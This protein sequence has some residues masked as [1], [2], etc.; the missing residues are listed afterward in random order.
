MKNKFLVGLTTLGLTALLFTSC[1]KVPQAEIDA[2][3]LAIEEANLAGAE[4][5]V[6]DAYVALQDSLNSVMVTIEAQESKFIKNYSQAKENLAGVTA[7]AQEVKLQAETRK[8]EVKV[9]AQNTINEVNA[10]LESNKTLLLQAPKGKEGTSALMAIK[11]E[12]AT[13]ETTIADA[14][15]NFETLG[16]NVVLEKVS[17]AKENAVAINT[18]LTEVIAKYKGKR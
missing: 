11:A 15:A 1:S 8:E 7:Y 9:E 16:Y 2:A 13:I 14:T 4:V 5:Y 3:N 17:A 12:L 18:E 10:L 6:H